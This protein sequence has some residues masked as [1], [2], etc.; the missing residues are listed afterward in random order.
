S[1]TGHESVARRGSNQ[2]D[3]SALVSSITRDISQSPSQATQPREMSPSPSGSSLH[4]RSESSPPHTPNSKK[5]CTEPEQGSKQLTQTGTQTSPEN[6]KDEKV[7]PKMVRKD[8]TVGKIRPKRAISPANLQ[9]I[10]ASSKM[11][12][13]GSEPVKQ[14]MSPSVAESLRAVFA[15]FLWHEGI[16]H[17][18][19]ACASFL[20]FHP[21]LPKQGALVVTR[22]QDL[23]L[24]KRRKE[25]TKEEKA[26]QRHSV[27]VSNA[28][29]YLH[30][31]PSTLES[32]TRSAANASANRNRRKLTD[33]I[34]KEEGEKFATDNYGYQT[35]SVLPPAL[36]S[37][38]YLWEELTSNCLQAVSQQMIL[39]SPVH[40]K[41][42][43]CDKI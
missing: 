35:I 11:N 13:P 28:G 5:E 31:Q 43:K 40:N 34:I 4:T 10:P 29:N 38:V 7:S 15:A 20:K 37:L 14:A 39:A 8:R 22:H 36:K 17:D 32:L 24:D 18:A 21:T 16:V 41:I 27:E 23:P 30:I 1:A 6:R 3:T 26:R 2:S 9:Q 19:M 12:Y 25:L 42:R 33:G